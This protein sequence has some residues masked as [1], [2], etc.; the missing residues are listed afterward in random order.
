MKCHGNTQVVLDG[1]DALMTYVS[2][3]AIVVVDGYAWHSWGEKLELPVYKL[4]GFPQGNTTSMYRNVTLALKHALEIWPDHDWYCV[5]DYDVLFASDGFKADLAKAAEQGIWCI[6]NDLR[7]LDKRFPHLEAVVGERIDVSKYLIGC[8]VFYHNSFLKKLQS[9]DF[10]DRMLSMT[11]GFDPGYFPDCEDVFDF[12]EHLYPT[13][14]AHFGGGLSQF[15]RWSD[16]LTQWCEGEFRKYPVR[17]KPDIDLSEIGPETSI[18]H[19]VKEYDC[20]IRSYCRGKRIRRK[21]NE[22]L[23]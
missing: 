21:K 14:A 5:L 12:G 9:I 2:R 10:F 15:S 1:L 20:E 11:N 18:I 16:S 8:C 23:S 22:N 3:D 13:L 17:W 4:P 19:P 7:D 6:G